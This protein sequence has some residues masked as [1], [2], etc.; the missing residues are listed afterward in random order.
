MA[1]DRLGKIGIQL[2]LKDPLWGFLYQQLPRFINDEVE[3]VSLFARAEG[4]L[5]LH[6]SSS[7][8]GK[9]LHPDTLALVQHELLHFLLQHPQQR[10]AFEEKDYFDLA[11]DLCVNQFM[12]SPF[13]PFSLS[14]FSSLYLPPFQSAR[15]YLEKIK[16]I[17][18]HGNTREKELID[19]MMEKS[20]RSLKKH[21]HWNNV[22][23]PTG[24]R[25][26]ALS[27]LWRKKLL[28]KPGIQWPEGLL[29][30]LNKQDADLRSGV[31]WKDQLHWM[32]R[33]SRRTRLSYRKNRLSRR[34]GVPPGLKIER[35]HRL[36]VAIDTSGSVDSEQLYLFFREIKRLHQEGVEMEILECDAGI[37]SRYRFS[38]AIP[39][40]VK[41]RGGTS[42]NQPI[43]LLN[44]E[45]HFG[46]LVY[47]TDGQGPAPFVSPRR[48]VLWIIQGARPA[49]FQKWQNWPGKKAI[50]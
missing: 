24:E 3:E 19:S 23:A 48:P 50:T 39:E 5:A 30:L 13:D 17:A 36:L 2:L 20:R 43:E 44:K 7:R 46:G 38:G 14:D 37:Q 42:Y 12:D 21:E 1:T 6:V 34:Y 26:I 32:A 9:Y 45:P 10:A 35:Q 49:D 28:E 41:G 33:S 18:L 29:A 4:L 31:N 25:A 8:A 16:D 47:F 40:M 22:V 27:N 15:F 11:A